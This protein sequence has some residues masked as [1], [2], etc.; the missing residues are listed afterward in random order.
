MNSR[1]GKPLGEH[2]ADDAV[3]LLFDQVEHLLVGD[4]QHEQQLARVEVVDDVHHLED[5]AGAQLAMTA[6]RGEL[7]QLGQVG[8]AHRLGD[9]ESRSCGAGS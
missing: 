7:E 9:R 6:R 5:R 3:D 2:A 1:M 8:L 4:G